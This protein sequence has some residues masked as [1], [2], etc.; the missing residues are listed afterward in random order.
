[1]QLSD[2]HLFEDPLKIHKE[3]APLQ[4]LQAAIQNINAQMSN[5]K[6]VII[7]GDLVSDI[8]QKT[9]ELLAQ[10]IKEIDAMVYVIPGNHDDRDLIKRYF[11]GNNISHEK[12]IHRDNWLI[13]LLDS[14]APG[15]NL[16]SGRLD[17][18]ELN[19]VEQLLNQYPQKDILIFIHHPPILFGAGWFQAICLENRAEF[20]NLI[21]HQK[22]VR[23]T[24]FGHGH[25][26]Y[27][28]LINNQLYI[29]APSTWRQ[30]D[31]TIDKYTEYNAAPG[32]Y[33]EYKLMDDGKLAF[34]TTYFTL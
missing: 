15:K 7:S 2:L 8:S 28:A 14:S 23:A 16:G 24:I 25:Y 4:Q 6:I 18:A 27:N 31:H 34:W 11:I 30:F 19:R 10:T 5:D 32:G 26:Q 22:N 17:Q 29:G 20:I 13:L 3:R 33:N 1:M 9:Y 12:E 21:Q